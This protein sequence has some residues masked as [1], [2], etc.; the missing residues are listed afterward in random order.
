MYIKGTKI[1]FIPIDI[2]NAPHKGYLLWITLISHCR[3]RCVAVSFNYNFKEIL[4]FS[5]NFILPTF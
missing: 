1:P 2:P 4:F 5:T 3:D